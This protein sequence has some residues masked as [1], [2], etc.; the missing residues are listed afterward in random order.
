MRVAIIGS[1]GA[2]I[3]RLLAR[4]G[5]DVLFSGSRDPQK[6]AHA[7]E[8]AGPNARIA[9]VGDAVEEAE[10]VVMAVP[11]QRYPDV[12]RDV[13]EALAGKVVIDTSN[14]IDVRDGWVEFL[15]VPDGL[16]AAQHQQ[17]RLGD[18]RLVK[19]F[20]MLCP[21]SI[22]ELAAR[23]GDERAAVPFAGDDPVAEGDGGRAH[24]G[25]GLRPGRCRQSRR[26][27]SI[28]PQLGR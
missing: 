18:V 25:R 19:A 5:H 10:V 24:R 7:A 27:A 26:R 3:G 2:D 12:A 8:L 15:D 17:S 6:L 14:P 16:T 4:A 20:N 13:G 1:A 23:T 22:H 11:F 28:G 21:S 9:S